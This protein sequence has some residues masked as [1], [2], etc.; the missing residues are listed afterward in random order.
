MQTVVSDLLSIIDEI[1]PFAIA[2]EWDNCGLQAGSFTWPAKKVVV[3]LDLSMEV[4]DHAAA[5]HADLV[6]THHPLMLHGLKKIDFSTMPGSAIAIAAQ[7]KISIISAHTNLDKVQGGLNDLF[8]SIIGLKNLKLLV[9]AIT[10]KSDLN[11]SCR[12]R[13]CYGEVVKNSAEESDAAASGGYCGDGIGRTGEL[14]RVFSL[15]EL[16]L[17]IKKKLQLETIRIAGDPDLPIKQVAL[18]TGSGGSL[19]RDFFRSGAHV[20]VTGDIKYHEAREIEQAGVGLI[21]VGHFASEQI[22]VN[23]LCE[24]IKNGAIKKGIKLEIEGFYRALDPFV[25]LYDRI[26]ECR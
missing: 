6:V 8:A 13:A 5:S 15:R 12:D 2:E 10:S 20:Y 23:L 26:E 9:P 3:S 18:C 19:L 24:K 4:M 1:A 7:E 17:Y 22:A 25:T 16:S 14:E 21:D 11:N